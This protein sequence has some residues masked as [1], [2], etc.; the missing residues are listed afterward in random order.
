VSGAAIATPVGI[1][2]GMTTAALAIILREPPR[3]DTAFTGFA[4]R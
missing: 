3:N 1:K 2:N 4:G